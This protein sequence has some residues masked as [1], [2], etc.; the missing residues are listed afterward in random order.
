[1]PK[2]KSRRLHSKG[3]DGDSNIVTTPTSITTSSKPKSNSNG[4]LNFFSSA[5]NDTTKNT[6]NMYDNLIYP[7]L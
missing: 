4:I 6:K 1:M 2:N 3:G 7:S 5:W